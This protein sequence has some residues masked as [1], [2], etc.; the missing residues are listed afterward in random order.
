MNENPMKQIKVEKVTINMGV[1]QA[2]EEMEKSK[3][4]LERITKRKPVET[5]SK[6]KNPTW[7][8]REGIPI[9]LKLTLRKQKAIEFLKIALQAKGKKLEG[10]NFDKRGNFAFG[11]REYI[12]IPTVKYDPKI[13]IRGMDVL[14]A[15]ERKGYRIKK[16]KIGKKKIGKKHLITKKEA[17]EFAKKEFDIEIGEKKSD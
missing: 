2:G 10:R 11:I 17:I 7:G 3:T 1:G 9:G 16:R 15:L 6:T 8:L 4:L 13:G 12:D 14:V 5:V